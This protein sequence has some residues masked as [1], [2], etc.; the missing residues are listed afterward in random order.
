MNYLI[1]FSLSTPIILSVLQ[2]YFGA[3]GTFLQSAF[4]KDVDKILCL[5]RSDRQTQR[6]VDTDMS[7]Y[8]NR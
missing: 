8:P 5:N 7:N 6:D 2:G 4:G 1:L 3:L